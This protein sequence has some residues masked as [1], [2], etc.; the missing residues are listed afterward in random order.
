MAA[1]VTPA[2]WCAEYGLDASAFLLSSLEPAAR[3]STAA[4]L[5]AVL[6]GAGSGARQEALALA[7][8][9]LVS[10]AEEQSRVVDGYLSGRV[11]TLPMAQA[12]FDGSGLV[13]HLCN[14]IRCHLA[15][16]PGTLNEEIKDGCKAAREHLSAI[17]GGRVGVPGLVEETAPSIAWRWRFGGGEGV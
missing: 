13:R 9:R 7:V 8:A 1:Y 12:T 15:T 2:R 4:D 14:L 3:G 5:E 17:A 10:A 16:A 11:S 6:A